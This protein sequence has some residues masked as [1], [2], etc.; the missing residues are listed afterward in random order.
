M[1][2]LRVALVP[3]A[4]ITFTDGWHVQGLK[5]TGSYD[6]QLRDGFVPEHRTFA[7]FAR[8]P[9]RGRAPTSGWG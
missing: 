5:G 2:D 1:P 6:Y 8:E 7:L 4:E 3:R 9:R